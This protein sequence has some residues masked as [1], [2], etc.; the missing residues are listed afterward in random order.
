M[1]GFVVEVVEKTEVWVDETCSVLVSSVL[2]TEVG[3]L[4]DAGVWVV[5][6][7]APVLAARL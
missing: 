5:G 4:V 7:V 3:E 6:V 2:R 1:L